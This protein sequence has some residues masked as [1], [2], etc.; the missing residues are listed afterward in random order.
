MS[1]STASLKKRP[2]KLRVSRTIIESDRLRLALGGEVIAAGNDEL[3][4]LHTVV[5]GPERFTSETLH[6]EG[7]WSVDAANQLQFKT[8]YSR[9]VLRFTG[10]WEI[11]P[12]NEL[13]YTYQRT[14][15]KRTTAT[16]QSLT[17]RGVWKFSSGYQLRYSLEGSEK[18]LELTGKIVKMTTVDHRAAIHYALGAGFRK[19]SSGRTRDTLVLFGNWRPLSPLELSFEFQAPDGKP[20]RLQLKGIYRLTRRDVA[21]FTFTEESGFKRPKLSVTL[22]RKLF[23][24]KGKLFVKGSTDLHRDH[25]IG[26][27]GQF[28]W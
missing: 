6:L 13:I 23:T 12:S 14:R 9:K 7:S 21:E 26:I 10:S 22:S 27:G 5:P 19:G 24:G 28:T 18:A 11:G 4:F 3:V 1:D 16:F 25:F 17:F 20:Y 15:E 8:R 2:H